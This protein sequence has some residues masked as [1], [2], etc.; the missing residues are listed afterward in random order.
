MIPISVTSQGDETT[1]AKVLSIVP[2][3]SWIAAVLPFPDQL[4]E[5]GP[6]D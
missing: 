6:Q 4:S 3:R 2:L 5:S 1:P